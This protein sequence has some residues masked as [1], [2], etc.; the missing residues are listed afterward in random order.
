[1]MDSSDL[2]ASVAATDWRRARV[3]YEQ[4][5]GEHVAAHA[6]RVGTGPIHDA[7]SEVVAGSVPG[8]AGLGPLT[9]GPSFKAL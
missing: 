8:G 5:L 7:T 2:V 6:G 9:S 4:T 1:M 3:F